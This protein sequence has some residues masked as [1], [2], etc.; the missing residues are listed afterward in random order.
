MGLF[1][2]VHQINLRV[3]EMHRSVKW[4]EEVLGLYVKHDYGD[5]VVLSFHKDSMSE[6]Q[7][8]QTSV[9][10]IQLAENEALPDF[11]EN[12]TYPV[13]TI[14]SDKAETCYNELEKLGVLVD[15]GKKGHFKFKDP[16]G[17]CLE[18]YLPGL[19]EKE[20]FKHLR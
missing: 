16:D 6:G 8:I 5:T 18:A 11:A 9:C 4:Y 14:A 17:N 12:G 1:Q 10:L 19:Y 13:F 2:G 20:R 3:K 15:G 7:L